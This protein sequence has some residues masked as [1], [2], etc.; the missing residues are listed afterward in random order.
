MRGQV[1]GYEG[2]QDPAAYRSRRRNRTGGNHEV[3]ATQFDWAR[4]ECG[5]WPTPLRF[6]PGNHDI[7]DNPPGIG[8][9]AK[10]PLDH[11][12]RDRDKKDSYE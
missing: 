4:E 6:L 5:A 7:G 9:P 3:D 11:V 12:K 2:S 10:D 1:R 8:V